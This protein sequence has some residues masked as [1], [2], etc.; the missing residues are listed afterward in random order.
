MLPRILSFVTVVS[1]C[2]C[3]IGKP[4]DCRVKPHTRLLYELGGGTNICFFSYMRCRVKQEENYTFH[5]YRFVP[6]SGKVY[7]EN[8]GVLY[9]FRDKMVYRQQSRPVHPQRNLVRFR[10]T[11][12]ACPHGM[13]Q[14][15]GGATGNALPLFRQTVLQLVRVAG[16]GNGE[17]K[18]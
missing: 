14:G 10:R 15:D 1:L 17:W 13:G 4:N 3:L 7:Y 16:L 5:R 6:R 11:H 9:V 18:M 2:L 8:G 12:I